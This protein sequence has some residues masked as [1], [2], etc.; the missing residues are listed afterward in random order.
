MISG[1]LIWKQ[2][3][4]KDEY[5]ECPHCQ[6]PLKWIWG[7][8]VWFPCDKEPVLFTMHPTGKL[9][10]IYKGK[11]LSN[12]VLYTPRDPRCAGNPVWGYQQHFYTCPHLKEQRA[13]YKQR[14]TGR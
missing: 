3:K 1:P 5:R 10:L 6:A 2:H 12:C 7:D 9:T 4:H 11:E 13:Q 8:G 14:I